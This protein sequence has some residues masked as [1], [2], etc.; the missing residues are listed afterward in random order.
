MDGRML[1]M[2][3]ARSGRLTARQKSAALSASGGALR[4]LAPPPG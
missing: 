2:V 3:N 1:V 4:V